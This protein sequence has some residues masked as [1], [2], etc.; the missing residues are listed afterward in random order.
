MVCLWY[1]ISFL[2]TTPFYES[3]LLDSENLQGGRSG[4]APS[5]DGVKRLGDCTEIRPYPE[6]R[7][8]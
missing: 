5:S 3:D 7:S 2:T 1:R 6:D 8:G 4:A